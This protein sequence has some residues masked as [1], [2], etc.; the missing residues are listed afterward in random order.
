MI[1]NDRKEF[2][3]RWRAYWQKENHERPVM[4][5]FAPSGKAEQNPLPDI[6]CSAKDRYVNPDIVIP[7]FKREIANTYYAAEDY[8]MFCPNVGTDV[9][10]GIA[11]SELIYAPETVWAKSFVDDWDA[12]SPMKFD[13]NNE[14]FKY[15]FELTKAAIKA[16]DNDFIIGNTDIHAGLDAMSAIRGS[17]NLCFDYIDNR[18]KLFSRIDELFEIEKEL[19]TR[20]DDEIRKSG[21][22]GCSSRMY[23][24][25]PD[26]KRYVTSCDVSCMIS[27]DD[28][29]ELVIPNLMKEIALFEYSIYH[30]DRLLK[31]DE[32]K[33]VQWVP[34]AGSPPVR[35]QLDIMKKIQDAGKLL[36]VCAADIEDV[37]AIC[38][39]LNPE[40]VHIHMYTSSPEEAD[41]AVKTA[42]EICAS[43]KPKIFL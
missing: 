16:C 33:G 35:Y 6:D 27:P 20:I 39:G 43:Q 17:E 2:D 29:E 3:N 9:V 10:A 31:I 38:T 21:Q 13:E 34:G 8:P 4:T 12:L 14:Y 19:F 28:F 25:H 26:R 7:A 22:N 23:I 32:L 42:E 24:Y 40:G 11:G 30:L 41:Y 36:T 5:V 15:A 37:K 1:F 18:E